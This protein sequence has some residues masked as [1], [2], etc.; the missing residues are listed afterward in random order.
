M[1]IAS[2]SNLLQGLNSGEIVRAFEVDHGGHPHLYARQSDQSHAENRR[3]ARLQCPIK[4]SHSRREKSIDSFSFHPIN[5]TGD[6][7][8][9]PTSACRNLCRPL[10]GTH[11]CHRFTW[12]TG[13]AIAIKI[14]DEQGGQKG[15][16]LNALPRYLYCTRADTS[17]FS[18]RE[19][20]HGSKQLQLHF[21]VKEHVC[22]SEE[23]HIYKK[24]VVKL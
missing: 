24:E 19:V 8:V 9:A 15:R 4:M 22:D 17:Y 7:I 5:E 12:T 1:I 3:Y 21:W 14:A 20:P 18:F 6:I 16:D 23:F 2:D 13:L 10:L 11:T